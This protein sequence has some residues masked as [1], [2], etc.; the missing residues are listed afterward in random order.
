[1]ANIEIF[2]FQGADIRVIEYEGRQVA[3]MPDVA[4][5]FGLR[6]D[7]VI[8]TLDP[9]DYVTFTPEFSGLMLT[10]GNMRG[11]HSP[12]WLTESGINHLS[13]R[14]SPELRKAVNE[15]ILPSLRRTGA[16][17]RP[18]SRKELAWQ[19]IQAEEALE[20]AER[21]LGVA[22]HQLAIAMPKAEYYDAWLDTDGLIGKMNFAR[23]LAERFGGK[24]K[25]WADEL[26]VG[27]RFGLWGKGSGD[28]KGS[29]IV[30]DHFYAGRGLQKMVPDAHG[31]SREWPQG[32]ATRAGVEWVLRQLEA[33]SDEDPEA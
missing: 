32:F 28:R 26:S 20:A 7:H 17:G 4:R 9:W 14:L 13:Y 21:Q 11:Q 19:V 23:I 15:E 33:S 10:S 22:A 2:R 24:I 29:I 25:E 18:L 1:V 16:Y 8:P 30:A 3:Y 31:G 27:G 6:S 5:V 12:Y